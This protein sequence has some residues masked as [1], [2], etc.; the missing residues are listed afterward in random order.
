MRKFQGI[1]IRPYNRLS[2]M[3]KVKIDRV[4]V[5]A[6][7]TLLGEVRFEVVGALGYAGERWP[8]SPQFDNFSRAWEEKEKIELV[9]AAARKDVEYER[10]K[11]V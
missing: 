5:E 1:E 10:A 2:E 7:K 8:V 11:T 9:I 4:H 3:P 6:L